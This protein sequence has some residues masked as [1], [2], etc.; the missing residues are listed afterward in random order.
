MH[1]ESAELA[2]NI[3]TR[4]KINGHRKNSPSGHISASS[5]L[6]LNVYGKDRPSFRLSESAL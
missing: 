5:S 4:K 2:Y 3:G 1:R 6:F